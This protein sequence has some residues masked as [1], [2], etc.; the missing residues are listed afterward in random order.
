MVFSIRLNLFNRMDSFSRL[1]VLL[2]ISS[3][4]NSPATELLMS[5]GALIN[6]EVLMV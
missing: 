6:N 3:P 2:N 4:Y 1:L 5:L